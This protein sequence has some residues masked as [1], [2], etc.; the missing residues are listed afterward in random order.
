METMETMMAAVR[1][2]NTSVVTLNVADSFRQRGNV[3]H[4]ANSHA[5]TATK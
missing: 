4:A 3:E 1:Y 5:L 2:F